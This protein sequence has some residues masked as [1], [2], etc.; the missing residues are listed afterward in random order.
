SAWNRFVV[1]PEYHPKLL[2]AIPFTPVPGTRLGVHP[3][4]APEHRARL[5]QTIVATLR[6][7]VQDSELSSFHILFMSPEEHQDLS[8]NKAEPNELGEDDRQG[9]DVKKGNQDDTEKDD[10]ISLAYRRAMQYHW[11]NRGYQTWEDFLDSLTSRRR[12]TLRKERT[13]I[14][15]MG[16]RFRCIEGKDATKEEVQFF[17]Q[18]YTVPYR[19]R[20]M[21]P[22]L[23]HA[24]F[25]QLFETMGQQVLIIAAYHDDFPTQTKTGQCLP[26]AMALNFVSATTVYGRHWGAIHNLGFL[27]FE[28]CYYQAI[29]FAIATKRDSVQAGVQGEHKLLRGYE[30]VA[31]HSAHF[32]DHPALHVA[33]TGAFQEEASDMQAAATLLEQALPYSQAAASDKKDDRAVDQTDSADEDPVSWRPSADS[34]T[35]C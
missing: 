9:D 25:E 30:P 22:Y 15:N 17:H 6:Q 18:L 1:Q 11:R 14:A 28:T 19:Q 5:R 24:T 16:Y 23:S 29:D 13:A 10:A 4:I 31:T 7:E 2:V 20:G 27:H 26:V 35:A 3:S 21:E 34:R 32:L 33:V 8:P 12:K